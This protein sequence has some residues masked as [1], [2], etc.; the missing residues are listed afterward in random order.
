MPGTVEFMTAPPQPGVLD[1]PVEAP[2]GDR[3]R[4]AIDKV[5]S[6]DNRPVDRGEMNKAFFEEFESLPE[7][8]RHSLAEQMAKTQARDMA[9]DVVRAAL[10]EPDAPSLRGI[11]KLV[12]IDPS[13]V[14]KISV[15]ALDQ[16][17]ELWTLFRIAL[18]LR[19]RVVV[20]F[21]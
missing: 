17:P 21:E 19:K 13:Q 9:A 16:G 8:I 3:I 12:G 2:S 7:K 6:A 20:S 5:D 15:G 14:S 10:Q 1:K 18:A 11:K 4:Q